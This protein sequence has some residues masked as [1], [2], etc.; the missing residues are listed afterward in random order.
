VREKQPRE[1]HE[2]ALGDSF[3]F[4]RIRL[5]NY[6]LNYREGMYSLKSG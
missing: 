3:G 4:G 2:N 1:I 6:S 5:E